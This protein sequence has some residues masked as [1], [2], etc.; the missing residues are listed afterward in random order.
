MSEDV[1]TAA[2]AEVIDLFNAATNRHDVDAMMAFMI[3]DCVFENT[4]P[5][6]DG[7]RYE[8]QKAVRGF[9]EDFFRTSPHATI[10]TEEL[11]TFANRCVV[12]WR[13]DWIDANGQAGHVRG[14]DVF[15]I[16]AGKIA[17]KLSYV[18]G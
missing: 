17:E 16:R 3:D 7:E 18:K 13:Y 12:R 15:L 14:V 4:Y 8:G 2:T 11:I 1:I 5:P 6:P 9:W 10:Q